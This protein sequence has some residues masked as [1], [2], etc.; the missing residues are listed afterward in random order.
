MCDNLSLNINVFARSLISAII[1][2][3]F[4]FTLSWKLSLATFSSI[5][6]TVMI[7]RV[8]GKYYGKQVR[9]AQN[10][11]A[12]ATAL[13]EEGLSAI[14]TVRSFAN[15]PQLQDEFKGQLGNYLQTTIVQ[16][17]LYFGYCTCFTALPGLVRKYPNSCSAFSLLLIKLASINPVGGSS[18]PWIRWGISAAR[19]N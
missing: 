9:K 4:M 18:S 12:K 16:S 7:S 2:L 19:R 8:Y 1:V 11:L 3:V 6:P 17:K 13:G 5:P 14:S 10:T 15:E